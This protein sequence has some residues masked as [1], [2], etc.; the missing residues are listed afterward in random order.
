[1]KQSWL[2]ARA[3]TVVCCIGLVPLQWGGKPLSEPGS[4]APGSDADGVK[5]RV[6]AVILHGTEVVS[7]AGGRIIAGTR[8]LTPTEQPPPDPVVIP[9][10][11]VDDGT[12]PGGRITTGSGGGCRA[13]PSERPVATGAP[14]VIG[15]AE[16][17]PLCIGGDHCRC[18]GLRR[19]LIT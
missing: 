3:P 6:P 2:D 17:S 14:A 1:M 4:R 9:W 16:T 7:C 13:G 18:S 5:H 8:G 19:A 15:T 10:A 12:P 11:T